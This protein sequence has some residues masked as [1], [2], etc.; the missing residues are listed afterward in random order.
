MASEGRDQCLRGWFA[1]LR[2]SHALAMP[3]SQFHSHS[4]GRGDEEGESVRACPFWSRNLVFK[5]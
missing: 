5:R 3:L 4:A 1:P 2:A